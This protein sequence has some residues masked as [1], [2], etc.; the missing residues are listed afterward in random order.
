[1]HKVAHA[2]VYR[3]QDTDVR[4]GGSYP[5]AQCYVVIAKL[6]TSTINPCMNIFKMKF[7]LKVRKRW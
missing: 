1:M 6:P 4:T 2:W 5:L 3:G 7:I